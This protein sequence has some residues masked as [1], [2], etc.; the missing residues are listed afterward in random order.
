M[1]GLRR[2]RVA[3]FVLPLFFGVLLFLPPYAS[4]GYDLWTEAAEV[5]LI[6]VQNWDI[7]QLFPVFK[8][9]SLVVIFLSLVRPEV[10]GRLLTLY[11]ALTYF[12]ISMNQGIGFSEEFGLII[13]VGF[14]LVTLCL[15]ATWWWEFFSRNSSNRTGCQ[16]RPYWM[17][18]LVFIAFWYPLEPSTLVPEFTWRLFLANGAGLSACMMTP[19]FL[20]ILI[21]RYPR[22]NLLTLYVTSS[23]GVALGLGNFY[24]NF[25]LYPSEM[26]WNGVLHLPLLIISAFALALSART[27]RYDTDSYCEPSPS[28]A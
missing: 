8:A 15:S 27:F 10:G 24:M 9:A 6:G 5:G 18:P 17:I 11:G 2:C 14:V 3:V 19:L 23:A 12:A 28:Q 4:R 22:V 25:L 21:W 1:I 7:P 26:W 20:A 13:N 16:R